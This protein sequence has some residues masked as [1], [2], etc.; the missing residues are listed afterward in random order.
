MNRLF[1]RSD[2]TK[3]EEPTPMKHCPYCAEEIQDSAVVCKHCRRSLAVP[4]VQTSSD[5][6]AHIIRLSLGVVVLAVLGALVVRARAISSD[7]NQKAL[8]AAAANAAR[9]AADSIRAVTPTFLPLLTKNGDPIA[10]HSYTFDEFTM[11]P[12]TA[13]T[14]VGQVT[15]S[16]DGIE[17]LV[18][19]YDEMVAWQANP[20]TGNPTW[21]SGLTTNAYV[22]TAIPIPGRYTVVISNRSAWL[23][24]HVVNTDLQLKCT[25]KWPPNSK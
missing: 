6:I 1:W 12:G 9:R 7:T 13:C 24:T 25:R 4:R 16:G 8:A 11:A 15:G 17:V 3:P 2:L 10:A 18:M 5:R 23:L 20:A 21:R 14:V 22:N 19:P